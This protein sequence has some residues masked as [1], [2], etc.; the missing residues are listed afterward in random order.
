MLSTS[1]QISLAVFLS[2]IIIVIIILS[3]DYTKVSPFINV[4]DLTNHPVKYECPTEYELQNK[5][6][7]IQSDT[8]IPK[9]VYMT[10]HDLSRIPEYVKRNIELYCSGYIIKIYNDVDCIE[11][12]DRYYGDIAVTI[13]K[14]METG[15]HKAD[16]WRYC[17]LYIFGGYYFDIKS[18]FTQHI[19]DVF[20]KH[21]DNKTWYGVICAKP[22][23]CLY[24]GIIVTPAHNPI[25]YKAI[26]HIYENPIPTH[27]MMYVNELLNITSDMSVLGVLNTGVNVQKN[28]WKCI[29]FQEKCS[30][31][32]GESCDRYGMNCMIHNDFDL[33]DI[34]TRY[35][36]FPW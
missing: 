10:Y 11:F 19:D 24:N 7:L 28:G 1:H 17:I 8:F 6:P 26:K 35:N 36:D 3:I 21:F 13:F 31:L 5:N 15:A 25:I 22:N 33:P 34:Q 27:Y 4:T 32:C 30:K 14:S 29:L 9:V 2:V 16:F 20:N 23:K 18:K 12:L